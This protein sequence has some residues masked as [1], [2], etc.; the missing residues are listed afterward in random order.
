[1]EWMFKLK[2]IRVVSLMV[3]HKMEGIVKRR[4]LKSQ[5]PL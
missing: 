4:G 1:M 5:G 2:N 3:G